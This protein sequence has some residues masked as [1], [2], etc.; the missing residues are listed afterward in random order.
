MRKTFLTLILVTTPT[1]V[2]AQRDSVPSR[3][4]LPYD[5][6]NEVAERWNGTNAVRA[7]DRLKV[8]DGHEVLGNVAVQHGPLVIAG[9][10]TGNVLAINSD[11]V[12][13][14]TAQV[15]GELLVVGGE[16]DGRD[17]AHVTGPIRIYRQTLQYREVGERIVITDDVPSEEDHWWHRLDHRHEDNW[18]EALR[19]VQA[20]PYNRVEG[21]PVQL[22][23]VLSRRTPWGRMRLEVNAI[24]RTG[25]SFASD[26]A[27]IGH[28]LRGDVR[29]GRHRAVEIG[30]QLMNVVHPTESWQ[31]SDVEV[32]LAAFLA[33]RDYRDYYQRHG[34][35]G[36]LTLYGARAVSLSASYGEERWSSRLVRNP[37]TLFNEDAP[38]RANPLVDE[39][40]FHLADVALKFDTRTDPDD[41]RTGWFLNADVEHGHGRIT[42]AAPTSRLLPGTPTGI[43]DYTRGL[44]DFRRYNR[45]GPE[46]QLNMRVLLGGWLNGDPL[47]LERRFSVDGPGALPGFGFR[48]VTSG[49]D[50]A[51]CNRGFGV[52]GRPAECDR[53]ALAQIEFRGDLRADL[54]GDWNE[55]PRHYHSGRGD[56]QWVFFADGGRGWNVGQPDGALTYDRASL[57]S[58]LTFRS[59][60]GLGLD[61]AGIGVYAAK[62]L[63]APEPV[64]FFVR[65]RHR[66]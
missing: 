21:L 36:F 49:T 17:V 40:L 30:A 63:S 37:F 14:S 61:F 42:A 32:A 51:T 57:P 55:W 54:T 38:W 59:D 22:G 39:G 19:V 10:V 48:S 24:V 45:L 8:D 20:G 28:N 16:V 65:L 2:T 9:H 50:A 29:I 31:M 58:I 3:Q 33:R 5:V 23:P 56:V 6:R 47:P 66:F 4:M 62:A 44:F 60:L 64:D 34:S 46:A 41:P 1:A 12:L 35:R 11:V 43:T 15:D 25:S 13:C 18:Q 27:D 7:S 53:F 26:R 52:P